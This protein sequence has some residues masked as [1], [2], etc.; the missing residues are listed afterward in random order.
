MTIESRIIIQDYVNVFDLFDI[1][2]QAAGVD[3]LGYITWLDGV[4]RTL[5]TRPGPGL[6]QLIQRYDASGRPYPR[7]DDQPSGWATVT[8]AT[9]DDD[10]WF[11]LQHDWF[12][13]ELGHWLNA[14]GLRWCWQHNDDVWVLGDAATAR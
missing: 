12:V 10:G 4:V 11:R 9:D 1:A 3:G 6:P 8:L 14:Q 2:R 5:Q 13:E 7:G